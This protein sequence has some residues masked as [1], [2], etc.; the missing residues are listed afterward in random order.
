[1]ILLFTEKEKFFA[2]KLLLNKY[3]D[4]V[5]PSVAGVLIQDIHAGYTK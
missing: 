3:L 2:E 1:M 4:C 5:Y